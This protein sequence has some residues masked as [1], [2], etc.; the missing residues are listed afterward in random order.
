M[1]VGPLPEARFSPGNHPAR[2]LK[3]ARSAQGEA[4]RREVEQ[5]PSPAMSTRAMGALIT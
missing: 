5:A 2:L 3:V 1:A 4:Q